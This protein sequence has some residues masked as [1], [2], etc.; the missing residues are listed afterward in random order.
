MLPA[1][2]DSWVRKIAAER[3]EPDANGSRDEVKV[4]SI[5]LGQ[6]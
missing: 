1:K 2:P 4:A 5:G 3:M 6:R